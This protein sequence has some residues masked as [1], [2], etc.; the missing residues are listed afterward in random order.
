MSHRTT[1]LLWVAGAAPPSILSSV[2]QVASKRR[3]QKNRDLA[4]VASRDVVTV[5]KVAKSLPPKVSVWQSYVV[6]DGLFGSRSSH[7]AHKE[8]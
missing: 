6:R 8:P 3:L 5:P 7:I 1:R 2:L 4:R